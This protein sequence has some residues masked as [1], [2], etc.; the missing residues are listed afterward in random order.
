MKPR[1]IEVVVEGERVLARVPLGTHNKYAPLRYAE[2]WRD[3]Y[4][5]LV[6]LGLSP[7]WCCYRNP[8]TGKH[9]VSAVSGTFPST[10]VLVARVLL[11]AHEGQRVEYLD[12]NT[13]NLRRENLKVASHGASK[14][15]ARNHVRGKAIVVERSAPKVQAGEA[16]R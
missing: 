11:D 4:D 12:G 16:V 10:R 7:N 9:Y 13:F 14:H 3:D 2:I 1:P 5:F 15:R 8:K 6:K